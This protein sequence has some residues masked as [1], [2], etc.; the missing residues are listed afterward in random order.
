M[1]QLAGKKLVF[2]PSILTMTLAV[3][4][5][6]ASLTGCGGGSSPAPPA[7]PPTFTSTPPTT[8][9]EGVAFNYAI[10]A[11]DPAGGSVSFALTSGPTGA[12]ITGSTLSWTPTHAE[13][14]VSDAFKITA[15]SSSNGTA[16][17]NFTIT[18]NGTINGTSIDHAVTTGGTLDVKEDL[19]AA[20]IEVLFPNGSGGYTTLR[21][22]G[23]SSGNFS[24]PNVPVGS[25]WLHLPRIV[26]GFSN[27][28]YLW[29]DASDIDAGGLVAGRPDAVIITSNFTVNA[30]NITV[31]PGSD[32]VVVWNS[33]DVRA[34]GLPVYDAAVANPFSATFFQFGGLIDS[35]KGDHAY[36][37]H[38]Q[39]VAPGIEAIVEDITYSSIT[40]TAG[41]PLTIT[42]SMSPV[43]KSS[44]RV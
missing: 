24:I 41:S 33:P 38:Y 42:G 9:Q 2:L 5:S 3:F 11:T 17:Q 6:L 13:S 31:T 23:D 36:L 12:A 21:G 1:R 43:S 29:T 18:P 26:Y 44:W 10:V 8:A 39:N 15:T 37:L 32:D 28:D 16:V 4:L 22:S 14:R 35:S 30:N 34:N 20:T 40:E 27:N 25:F 19:S 7:L